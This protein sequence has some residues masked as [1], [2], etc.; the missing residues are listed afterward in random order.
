MSRYAQFK[1]FSILFGVVYTLCFYLQ[2]AYP[3]SPWWAPFRYYPAIAEWHV[4][5]Q[6]PETAGPAILWYAWLA[7]AF[8]FSALVSVVVPRRLADRISAG[9]VWIIPAALIVVILVYERRWFL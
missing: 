6:P 8:V 9:S 2:G 5:R 4:E 1:V 7:E 3:L